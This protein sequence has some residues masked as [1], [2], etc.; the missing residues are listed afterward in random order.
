MSQREIII[1]FRDTLIVE[2][3]GWGKMI[4][5]RK[6][7]KKIEVGRREK[8]VFHKKKEKKRIGKK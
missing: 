7:K 1:S 6:R 3:D 2:N 5:L 8:V 4:R